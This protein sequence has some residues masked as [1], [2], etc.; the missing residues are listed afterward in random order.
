MKLKQA[1]HV[2]NETKIHVVIEVTKGHFESKTLNYVKD[3]ESLR[4]A[5]DFVTKWHERKVSFIHY[6]KAREAIEIDC[7]MK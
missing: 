4:E 2:V 3:S 6:N 5:L 7:Y 1:L